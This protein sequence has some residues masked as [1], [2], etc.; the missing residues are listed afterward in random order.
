MELK[1]ENAPGKHLKP[2]DW[3]KAVITEKPQ[4]AV[5]ARSPLTEPALIS[6]LPHPTFWSILKR[7]AVSEF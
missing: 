1:D 4:A 3:Q 5:L 2:F 7:G 6:S